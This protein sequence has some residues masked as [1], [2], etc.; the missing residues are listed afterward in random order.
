MRGIRRSS[1]VLL[2]VAGIAV[3]TVAG[4]AT[5]QGSYPAR[6]V[7]IIVPFPPGGI[8]DVAARLYARGLA[9]ALGQQFVI[10]NRPGGG[11][12]LGAE[13]AARATPDGHTLFVASMASH[14]VNPTLFAK[15]SYDPERD[16]RAV[17]Q[18][19]RTSLFLIVTPSIPVKSVM[20]LVEYA[21]ARPGKI[22]YAS[23]GIGS[24]QQLAA[25]LF[26]TRFSL[27]IA[28]VAYKGAAPAL[29]DVVSG[30]VPIIFDG[31]T[32]LPL[33]REGRVRVVATVDTQRWPYEPDIP[34]FAEMGVPDFRVNG[35]FGLVAPAKTPEAIVERINGFVARIAGQPDTKKRM[36]ELGMEPVVMS[37]AQLEVFLRSERDRWRP[38]IK[39]TGAKAE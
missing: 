13:I 26:K 37:R 23:A 5:A 17:G 18:M 7:R 35:F 27:D 16:F 8:T 29:L 32:A 15:L 24:P 38:I 19:V 28:H 9:E 6:P 14:V 22:T 1:C 20:D 39:A 33:A 34:S 31:G 10:E 3:S 12:T 11:T 4:P 36:G 2:A 21:K 30:Q 25:E